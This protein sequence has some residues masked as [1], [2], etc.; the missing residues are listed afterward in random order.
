MGLLPLRAGDRAHHRCGREQSAIVLAVGARG[1]G[2]GGGLVYAVSEA[3]AR[4]GA[5]VTS[6]TSDPADAYGAVYAELPRSRF[7]EYRRG[8]LPEPD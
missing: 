4:Y 5:S 7:V 1:R 8:W 2:V 3:A 6:E